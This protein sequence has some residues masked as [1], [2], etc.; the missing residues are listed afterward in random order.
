[1]S[2]SIG[3][4]AGTAIGFMVGGPAGAAQGYQIGSSIDKPG[5]GAQPSGMLTTTETPNT[6]AF[7]SRFQK[8]LFN[9]SQNTANQLGARQFA[10]FSGLQNQGLNYL[11]QLN[12]GFTPA[13]IANAERSIAGNAANAFLGGRIAD[14]QNPYTEQVINQSLADIDRAR[15]LQQQ[16]VNAQALSRGAF[17]GSRQAVAEA[18]NARNFLDQQARTSAG[19]RA[20]SYESALAAAQADR[21][22]QAQNYALL[23][24]SFLGNAEAQLNAGGLQQDLEQQRLDASR[25]LPL[26]RLQVLQSTLKGGQLPTGSSIS[27]PL[28]QNQQS[29]LL[30]SLGAFAANNPEAVTRAG[31]FLGSLPGMAQNAYYNWKANY[32]TPYGTSYGE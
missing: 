18:E 8:N 6:P 30:G 12:A 15:Q 3:R 24:Q 10:G 16:Q 22:A 11:G 17:G 23:N 27:R 7:L 1:M 14:Y 5:G 21:Q 2:K 9:Q 19:L 32:G 26:E 13:S 31:N 28:F 20:Q 4:I 29:G 25:N